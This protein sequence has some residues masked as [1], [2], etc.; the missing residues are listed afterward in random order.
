M[1]GKVKRPPY[2]QLLAEIEEL[3]Y[4]G[5]GRKY[6]VSDNAIRKWR[7][8]YERGGGQACAGRVRATRT[9]RRARS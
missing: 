1:K 6:G 9:P 4:L 2:E 7:I 3:G 8:A 5:V